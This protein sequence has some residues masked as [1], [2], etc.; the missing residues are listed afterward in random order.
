MGVTVGGNDLEYAI[1]DGE[2]GHVEGAAT[3]GRAKLQHV[4]HSELDALGVRARPPRLLPSLARSVSAGDLARCAQSRRR[5]RAPWSASPKVGEQEGERE[6]GG[7]GRREGESMRRLRG[8][9][10]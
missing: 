6:R 2:H 7:H 3:E 10:L 4:G 5:H 1:V 8:C 9:A